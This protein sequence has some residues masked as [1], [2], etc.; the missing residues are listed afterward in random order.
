MKRH[1]VYF[2]ASEWLD[3]R[4]DR[5]WWMGVAA[6]IVFRLWIT[7]SDEI[8]P[9]RD[10]S[11][12]YARYALHYLNP[13]AQ[14]NLPPQPPGLPM[15][16]MVGRWL[17]IPFKLWLDGIFVLAAG[18]IAL[19]FRRWMKSQVSSLALFACLVLNPWFLNHTVVF[20]SEPLTSIL[21]LWMAVAVA[22]FLMKPVAQWTVRSALLGGALAALYALT[23]PELILAVGF[24]IAL[25]LAV[26]FSHWRELRPV[27]RWQGHWRV[28]LLALPL[29]MPLISVWTVER[30]HHAVYGV[31][32][33]SISESPALRNLMSALYTIPPQDEIRF[34]PVTYDSLTEACDV[35]PTLNAR[36]D[37]LLNRG[38][39]FYRSARENLHLEGEFGT[40]L[41]WLLVSAFNSGNAESEREMW[42]AAEEIRNAQRSGKLAYRRAMF[43]IDPLWRQWLPDLPKRFWD[44]V[45]MAVSP[46]FYYLSS[47]HYVSGRRVNQLVDAGLF[48]DALLR[49]LGTIPESIIRIQGE[50]RSQG[51][52]FHA[53]H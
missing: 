40:W 28:S 27:F 34:A 11:S 52:T 29:L 2:R 17:G 31:P 36:R 14:L 12:N 48:D 7:A 50:L 5:L 39:P 20:M 30:V 16:A 43:P 44:S 42:L 10:D 3:T 9:I 37:S 53:V 6:I 35:C 38:G 33:L 24:W 22:P 15:V 1:T 32:A 21:V 13:K 25:F 18:W 26:A 8:L 41:N 51:S 49:R 46:N 45:S 19:E 47:P 4:Q 23:R